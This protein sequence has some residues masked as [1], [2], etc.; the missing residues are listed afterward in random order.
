MKQE[1]LMYSKKHQD[2]QT[3]RTFNKSYYNGKLF[4]VRFSIDNIESISSYK[5]KFP[6]TVEI[7]TGIVKKSKIRCIY[8]KYT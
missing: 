4:T 1:V 6:D 3:R 7:F 2:L 5:E 8:H